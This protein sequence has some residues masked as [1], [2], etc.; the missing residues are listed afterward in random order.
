M[1]ELRGRLCKRCSCKTGHAV[2]AGKD[3]RETEGYTTEI[4]EAIHLAFREY[5]AKNEERKVRDKSG[6]MDQRRPQEDE[7]SP[8]PRVPEPTTTNSCTANSDILSDAE[9]IARNARV[10][11][12]SSAKRGK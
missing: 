4:V 10:S 3:T 12:A 1:A 5:A 8:G 7:N 2:C 6:A 9:S 11:A